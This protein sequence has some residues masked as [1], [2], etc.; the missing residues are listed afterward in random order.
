MPATGPYQY[1]LH[2]NILL[3]QV[4]FF[5]NDSRHFSCKHDYPKKKKNY[6]RIHHKILFLQKLLKNRPKTP[7]FECEDNITIKS[8]DKS[9]CETKILQITLNKKLYK[10]KQCKSVQFQNS[11]LLA[12]VNITGPLA[13][14]HLTANTQACK[15]SYSQPLIM[16]TRS[17]R[18]R[19]ITVSLQR[20]NISQ[21]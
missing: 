4:W 15:L 9:K 19:K 16:L 3:F 20:I 18:S 21:L 10:R 6:Y 7:N 2:P 13:T 12:V 5:I 11:Q 17:A 8:K 14:R 1:S